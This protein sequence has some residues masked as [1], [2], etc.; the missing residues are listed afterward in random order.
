MHKTAQNKYFYILILSQY[1]VESDWFI[2]QSK[3]HKIVQHFNY[4]LKQINL[5]QLQLFSLGITSQ[6]KHEN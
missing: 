1:M 6:K 5:K 4:N 2:S 3:A